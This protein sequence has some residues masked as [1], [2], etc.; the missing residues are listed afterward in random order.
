M[1]GSGKSHL[2]KLIKNKECEI[3]GS[4]KVRVLSID[5]YFTSEDDADADKDTKND[6]RTEILFNT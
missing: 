4:G 6:V 5:D 2:A 3:G 1:P